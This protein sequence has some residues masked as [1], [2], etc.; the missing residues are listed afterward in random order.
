VAFKQKCPLCGQKLRVPSK[1]AG[2]ILNCPKCK[3]AFVGRPGRSPAAND[4]PAWRFGLTD[5]A[6]RPAPARRTRPSAP[7]APRNTPPSENREN[8]D[9]K[10]PA[11]APPPPVPPAPAAG[12]PVPPPATR[13]LPPAPRLPSGPGEWGWLKAGAVLLLVWWG[14][15]KFRAP[16]FPTR[17]GPPPATW[18]APG[19]ATGAN[20]APPP[21]SYFQALAAPHRPQLPAEPSG[22]FYPA[23]S[24]FPT[25]RLQ[26]DGLYRTPQHPAGPSVTPDYQVRGNEIYRTFTHPAG[27]STLPDYEAR[28]G[29]VYRTPSHPNGMSA[30]PA[31][32]I[33]P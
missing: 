30:L 31:G 3:W 16:E 26:G 22:S 25:Y 4:P 5:P 15:S 14:W 8:R 18:P 23:T 7:A 17:E 2:R 9:D 21:P 6:E 24:P 12:R 27:A 19:P 11:P 28:G 20:P 10:R 13:P 33:R 32:E 1:L 29:Q